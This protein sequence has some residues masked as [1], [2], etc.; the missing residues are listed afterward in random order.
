[1]ELHG[2]GCFGSVPKIKTVRAINLRG[3]VPIFGKESGYE[4]GDIETS[5]LLSNIAPRAV[6]GS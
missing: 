3:A 5:L 1:M 2:R 4:V 6:W